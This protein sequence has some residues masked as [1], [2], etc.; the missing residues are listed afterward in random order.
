MATFTDRFLK[1]VR[2]KEKPYRVFEKGADKGFGIQITPTGSVSFFI[3]YTIGSSKRFMNLGRYPS[4]SLSEAREKCRE[5]RL[6]VD[7]SIDPQAEP[8]TV[9]AEIKKGTVADLFTY[10]IESMKASGKRSWPEVQSSFEFNCANIKTMDAADVEPAHIRKILHDIIKRNSETQANRVRSYLHRAFKLGMQHDNDPKSLDNEFTFGI[11]SNPVE[12]IPRNTAAEKIGERTLTFDEIAVIW[13]ADELSP[14]FRL[15]AR[16]LLL[17]GCRSWELLGAK[18]DEFDFNGMIWSMI[19][20][21]VK[22]KRIHLLPITTISAA[23]LEELRHYSRDS[24]YLFPSRYTD[25]KPISETSFAHACDRIKG[26]DKFC[27]RDFRRTTKTRMGEIGINKLI[28][29]RIQNHAMQDVS[30]KHYD[31]YDYMLEKREALIKWGNRLQ[32]L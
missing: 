19:P 16:L 29:D 20:E 26:I 6:R 24:D 30:A 8:E 5:A 18:W 4:T 13:N 31:R 12:S 3:Q 10:Y 25:D 23:W 14:Q 22:N 28:R 1:G 32:E 11:V 27:P 15:A 21:R 17:Y 2:P 9:T 7:S